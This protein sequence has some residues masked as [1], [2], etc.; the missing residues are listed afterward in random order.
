MET[1]CEWTKLGVFDDP[2][3]VTTAAVA[4]TALLVLP[5]FAIDIV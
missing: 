4:V 1:G 3:A 5:Q 2:A